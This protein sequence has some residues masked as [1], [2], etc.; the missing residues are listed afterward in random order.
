MGFFENLFLKIMDKTIHKRVAI[1]ENKLKEKYELKSYLVS[2]DAS[3]SLEN[4]LKR[5]FAGEAEPSLIINYMVFACLS[6]TTEETGKVNLLVY[7]NDKIDEK[8]DISLKLQYLNPLYSYQGEF[9]E[10]IVLSLLYWGVAYILNLPNYLYIIKPG[11]LEDVV[12]DAN[13]GLPIKYKY[14]GKTY[15]DKD[16]IIIKN[17]NNPDDPSKPYSVFD[18]IDGIASLSSK[19]IKF[20]R[21]FFEEGGFLPGFFKN[22]SQIE[23][24]SFG[25]QYSTD[26]LREDQLFRKV[27]RRVKAGQAALLPPNYEYVPAGT[28]PKDATTI[29]IMKH[30]EDI[31]S[32]AFKVPKSI[33]GKISS[34]GSF[35]LTNAERKIFYDCVID[36]Y[37]TKIEGAFNL[38]CKR[39]VDDS[40][41]I[42][43]DTSNLSY[44][45]LYMLDYATQIAQIVG[46]GIMTKNEARNRFFNLEPK[47]GGDELTGIS[48][49][50]NTIANAEEAGNRGNPVK[51]GDEKKNK[52]AIKKTDEDEIT[53]L[54]KIIQEKIEKILDPLIRDLIIDLKD[55]FSI[56][57]GTIQVSEENKD[58]Q[59]QD[60]KDNEILIL[61]L[62]NSEL[63][64]NAV[65][66][67]ENLLKKY[68]KTAIKRAER[69]F[70]ETYEYERE[71]IPEEDYEEWINAQVKK[72]SK[73]FYENDIIAIMLGVIMMSDGSKTLSDI[74]EDIRNAIIGETTYKPRTWATT[75]MMKSINEHF[76][77]KAKREEA[78][79]KKVLKTWRSMR[80]EK[81]R[82]AHRVADNNVWIP[83]SKKFMLTT[84]IGK[85]YAADRPYDPSLPPELIINCRCFLVIKL[86]GK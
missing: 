34:G 77:K 49:N 11:D 61:M 71:D 24:V 55:I 25:T 7:S 50:I 65:L 85:T 66:K 29:D 15:T 57:A 12:K 5:A 70:S 10:H 62:I 40:I 20:L 21:N 46:A 31:I 37:I 9:I 60:F 72:S 8:S 81:V 16:I 51:E 27:M 82:I 23:N 54:E 74:V 36:K 69:I 84:S 83:L 59:K 45:K 1:E 58:R 73:Y 17:I 78:L 42:K 44:L 63:M 41:T 30:V 76:Y 18:S 26:A 64:Q 43:R 19:G 75:E 53:E 14:K 68:Y 80:D 47:P 6:Y 35:S 4:A 86:A 2:Q 38:Y 3:N 52:S 67:F 79:G 33:I 48:T 13:T 32:V 22:T 39:F 56:V 28:S